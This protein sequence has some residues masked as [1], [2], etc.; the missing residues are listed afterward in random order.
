MAKYRDLT[1]F[2]DPDLVLPI[3]DVEY[4]IKCPGRTEGKR[5][6]TLI[7]DSQLTTAGEQTEIEK[8]LGEAG[9]L[10]E[11][12]NLPDVMVT[13]AGR[14]ALIHFGGNP[15]MGRQHWHLAQLGAV[16]S[17]DEAI[18]YITGAEAPAPAP[19]AAAEG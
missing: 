2:F 11:A 18:E 8:I 17:L 10:M 16:L 5:L 14:T 4:R 19:E 15:D 13:H 3:G 9:V 12:A 7:L 1:E 6:R